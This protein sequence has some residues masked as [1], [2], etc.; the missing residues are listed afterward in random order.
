MWIYVKLNIFLFDFDWCRIF[1]FLIFSFK[2]KH[3]Q[4]LVVVAWKIYIFNFFLCKSSYSLSLPIFRMQIQNF[5]LLFF[6]LSWPDCE[7][8]SCLPTFHFITLQVWN[9]IFLLFALNWFGF[10]LLY[11][12][13]VFLSLDRDL[14][15]LWPL[16]RF[17]G[18][19]WLKYL[20]F[21][22]LS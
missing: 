1:L 15:L 22:P 3:V 21:I 2:D 4:H 11:F 19:H 17:F 16:I 9:F 14:Q 20:D 18:L 5:L 7:S 10:Y 13:F 12:S 6:R 8:F